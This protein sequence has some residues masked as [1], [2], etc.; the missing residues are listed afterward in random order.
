MK[1]QKFPKPTEKHAKTLLFSGFFAVLVSRETEA[2][3]QTVSRETYNFNTHHSP[4]NSAFSLE[5]HSLIITVYVLKTY[6]K[7]GFSPSFLPQ[8]IHIR[9]PKFRTKSKP[10]SATSVTISPPLEAPG[11]TPHRQHLA[12]LFFHILPTPNTAC[13]PLRVSFRLYPH[14]QIFQELQNLFSTTV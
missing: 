14:S 11:K 2:E 1:G 3:N 13:C 6:A 10:F 12:R 5:F 7:I 8:I 4:A 9:T